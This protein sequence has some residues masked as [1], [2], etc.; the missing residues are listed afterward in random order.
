MFNRPCTVEHIESPKQHL[1]DLKVKINYRKNQANPEW[2]LYKSLDSMYNFLNN[3]SSLL[4]NGDLLKSEKENLSSTV[5][6]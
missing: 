4:T 5:D 6:F 1:E 2:W 3:E